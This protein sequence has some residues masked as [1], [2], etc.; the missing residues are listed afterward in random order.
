[1]NTFFCAD[2]SRQAGEDI[3]GSAT[4]HQTYVLIECPTPWAAEAF[5]SRWVPENLRTLVKEVTQAKVPIRFLLISNG[6][7]HKTDSTTLLIYH[8]K[9][10]LGH[11]YRKQEWKL[12]NIEQAATLIKK[13]LW[14]KCCDNEVK[15]TA[16]RDILIC[17]HGSHDKCCAKY[18]NPFYYEATA[19]ISELGLN[20][21][22]VWKASHF[23]GHRFAP[24][25]IDLP[26]GRYYGVLDST[27]FKSILTRTGD[28]ECLK[29]VY[30]GWGTLPYPL[31][32]ME[33]ELILRYGWDWFDYK[34][35]S[36]IIEQNSD[37]STI[38]AEMSFEK[39]DGS[40]KTYQG[41][42]VKDEIKTLHI[43]GSCHAS[44]KSLFVKYDV[45]NLLPIE[46][47][48]VTYSTEKCE[49]GLSNQTVP[50]R[51]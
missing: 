21:I 40:Q 4:N 6:S 43:K 22:R 7:S 30:R 27:S 31:Q 32:T 11:G 50:P 5:D 10:K 9:E 33:R 14:G 1:M 23:G 34:V 12:E 29:K 24:T 2:S 17:T 42:L 38:H 37:A 3:I 41:I 46:E 8:R 49:K 36:R 25:A 20:D 15:A 39:P 16:T 19:A 28:I 26:E 18:G 48:L 45:T 35:A 13:W 47:R 44:K 51:L